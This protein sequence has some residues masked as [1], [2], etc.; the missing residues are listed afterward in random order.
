M[1]MSGGASTPTVKKA[2]TAPAI[3]APIEADGSAA[4]AGADERKRRQ[5]ASGRSDTILTSGLGIGLQAGTTGK[6]LLGE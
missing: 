5:A 1:C 2:P 6:R 4:A 3:I